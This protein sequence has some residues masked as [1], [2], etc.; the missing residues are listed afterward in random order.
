MIFDLSSPFYEALKNGNI[1]PKEG[2]K[3]AQNN[4]ELYRILLREYINSAPDRT[5]KMKSYV[6]EDDRKKYAIQ[7]HSLKSTSRTIGAVELSD[8]ALELEKAADGGDWDTVVR[9]NPE[10]LSDYEMTVKAVSA[11]LEI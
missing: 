2:L 4:E 11:A 3:Y 1:D 5:A 9:E 10:L 7:V 8:R 6:S